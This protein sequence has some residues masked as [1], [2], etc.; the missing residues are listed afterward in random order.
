MV[1]QKE[2]LDRLNKEKDYEEKIAN[3]L[4][5]YY[6]ISLEGIEDITEEQKKIIIASLEIIGNDSL[7]HASAFNNLITYVLNNGETEY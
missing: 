1:N 6:V 3:D 2:A 4:L 7:M 5:N